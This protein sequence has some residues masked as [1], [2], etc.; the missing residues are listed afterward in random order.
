MS[1]TAGTLGFS[2][3]LDDAAATV[4][5]PEGI[6]GLL[7]VVRAFGERYLRLGEDAWSEAESAVQVGWHDVSAVPRLADA[8]NSLRK[9]I[10][11]A[12]A[13]ERGDRSLKDLGRRNRDW[14]AICVLFSMA[15]RRGASRAHELRRLYRAKEVAT[16]AANQPAGGVS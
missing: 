6:V 2:E 8:M 13:R 1:E 9:G 5:G 4:G 16:E 7:R 3:A 15:Y 14:T 12:Y 10:G 11:A